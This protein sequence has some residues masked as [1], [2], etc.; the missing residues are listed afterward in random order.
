MLPCCDAHGS[1]K[2]E[3][4]EEDGDNNFKDKKGTAVLTLSTTTLKYA[5]GD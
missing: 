3:T 4:R 5:E 2:S 1:R